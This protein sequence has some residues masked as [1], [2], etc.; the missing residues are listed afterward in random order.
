MAKR[1][2]FSVTQ[3][4]AA[5]QANADEVRILWRD[6]FRQSPVPHYMCE[7]CRFVHTNRA[8]FEVD[9]LVSCKEGGN[10][11]RE[12]V[13]RIAAIEAEIAK[14]LDKQD[15]GVLA[16]ANLNSQILC[17]GCNQGKK[18]IGPRPDD[19]PTACGF[20]YA[21]RDED[22]NPD[23]RYAGPPPAAGYIKPQY[24]RNLPH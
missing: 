7:H 13:E 24:R 22:M 20:A 16:L 14:P 19:I 23:H 6:D 3:R 10:A 15:I 2:N 1:D 9:H 18:G 17:G 12:T 5:L 21:K 4:N 8:Y 11:N